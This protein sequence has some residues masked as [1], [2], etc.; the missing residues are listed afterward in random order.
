M[1]CAYCCDEFTGR[2]VKQGE[3]DYCSVEC[4]NLAAGIEEEEGP[5]YYDEDVLDMETYDE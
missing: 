1:R 4:A 3:E 5:S 2:P